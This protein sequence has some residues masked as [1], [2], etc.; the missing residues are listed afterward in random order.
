MLHMKHIYYFILQ[1]Q[2]YFPFY[3][4][5]QNNQYSV[6]ACITAEIVKLWELS[7]THFSIIIPI[8]M[9][10]YYIHIVIL[11]STW[12]REELFACKKQE[13]TQVNLN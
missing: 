8:E 3:I 4:P 5:T 11:V 13:P 6:L 7:M 2:V 1:F 12:F 9:I 10:W